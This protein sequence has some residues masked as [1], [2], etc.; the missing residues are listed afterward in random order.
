MQV[1]SDPNRTLASVDM[2]TLVRFDLWEVFTTVSRSRALRKRPSGKE[3]VLHDHLVVCGI[4]TILEAAA[5]ANML[6]SMLATSN[7][8]PLKTTSLQLRGTLR[9][10][11][12]LNVGTLQEGSTLSSFGL[13]IVAGMSGNKTDQTDQADGKSRGELHH[14]DLCSQ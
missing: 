12:S 7:I 13:D 14:N 10:A 4:F 2:S 8:L 6:N 9:K 3:L 5:A 11:A 1:A